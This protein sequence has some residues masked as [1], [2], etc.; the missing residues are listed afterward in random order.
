MPS[1]KHRKPAR[2]QPDLLE[3]Y[4]PLLS[5]QRQVVLESLLNQ[6]LSSAIRINSLMVSPQLEIKH[7]VERYGWQVTPVPFCPTGWKVQNARPSQT[8]E[9]RLGHYFIQEAASMLPVELFDLSREKPLVLDMAA[10]PGGKTTHLSARSSDRGLIIANDA[11]A[12]RLPGLRAVLQGSGIINA[13]VT[14]FPGEFFGSWFPDTFDRA[15]L[16]APCS[17]ENLRPLAA[18]PRRTVS[19]RERISLSHRQLNLLSSA[20][21][22][23]KLGGQIV[24]STCTLAPEEDEAVLDTLLQQ[25]PGQVCIEDVAKKVGISAPGLA[26]YQ[27]RSFDPSLLHS[28]RLWPDYLDTSGFFAALL[29]KVSPIPGETKPAPFRSVEEFALVQMTSWELRD[30][31]SILQDDY[32]FDLPALANEEQLSIWRRE[33]NIYA[34]P[35]RFFDRFNGLPVYSLGLFIGSLN[36]AS[37][38]PS[39]E[40]AARFGSHFQS[41]KYILEE[42]E[43]NLWLTGKAIALSPPPDPLPQSAVII[44]LDSYRN[45]LGRGRWMNGLLKSL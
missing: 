29:T 28:I 11:S 1:R 36:D 16:D 23:I 19:T 21:R 45:N 30:L 2:V 18:H 17:M 6:P 9:F 8:M 38:T 25:F 22:S 4:R 27:D 5:Y 10:A 14:N 35:D 41:G 3:K 34:L 13:A 44:V 7:L 40:F 37:F 24:Y 12:A 43:K 26:S 42:D 15:L 32:G 20:L 33:G 31:T 39:R